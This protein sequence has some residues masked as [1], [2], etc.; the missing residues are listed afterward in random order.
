[1]STTWNKTTKYVVGIGLALLGIYLLYLSRSVLP[2]LILAALIAGVVRPIIVWLQR[3]ARLSRGVAVA[4]VYLLA[5]ILFP[6]LLILIVPVI[7]NAFHYVISIDYA[8]LI[9]DINAWLQSMLASIK[10]AQLPVSALDAYVDQIIEALLNMLQSSEPST[11]G[12]LPS[13]DK[14]M[15]SIGT[16]LAG[17]FGA[18]TSLVGSVLSQVALLVFMFLASIYMSLGA[19]T[20]REKLLGAVPAAYRLEISTLLSRVGG[21][22][23]AYFRGELTLMLVIGLLCGVGLAVLG[24][25]GALYLGIIAGLLELIP[26]LGP[27][28]AIIP[29][30]IVA[31]LQGSTYLPVSPL[32]LAGLV[33]ILYVVVQ[34]LE[35]NLIVPHVLGEA[36]GL[37]AL[38]VLTGVVVGTSVA[39]VLGALLVTPV[40]ASG[41][42]ILRYIYRKMLGESPFSTDDEQALPAERTAFNVCQR[43]CAWFQ[44]LRRSRHADVSQAVTEASPQT[45]AV[46]GKQDE[47]QV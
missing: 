31:L 43:L 20:Y 8:R 21:I 23:S 17:T 39:G 3:R 28:I 34:Q 46:P 41:R 36:V 26:N 44:R 40:I 2:M 1:M 47:P 38:V 37:P 14:V 12:E 27:L 45:E 15:Q 33:L 19:H 24:V 32:M 35:N 16:A 4:L 10:S 11:A 9:Q 6:V 30:V 42:E 25:P 22:W 5:L 7:I 13:M 18:A 29:A